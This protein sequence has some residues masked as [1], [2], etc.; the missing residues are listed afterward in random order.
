VANRAEFDREFGLFV[1]A[2][3]ERKLPCSLI[4]CDLDRFKSIN[5]TYGHPA[6]DSV[7]KSFGQLLKSHCRPG[8]LVARYGG[9]EFVVLC[10]DCTNAVAYERAEAMR[11]TFCDLTQENMGGVR[12]SASFGVTEIQ[13]GDSPAT[14][15]HRADRALLTAKDNGRNRVVQLGSGVGLDPKM[16]RRSW[17][18]S[19]GSTPELLVEQDLTTA[20]PVKIAVE[21]L[22]GFVADHGA[23]IVAIESDRVQL[24]IDVLTPPASG[25]RGGD[26]PLPLLVD[27]RFSQEATP[28]EFYPD[29]V[30]RTRIHA[31]IRLHK[32]RNRRRGEAVERARQLMASVRSYLMAS[33]EKT[34]REDDRGIL[35]RAVGAM[36]PWLQRDSD[37]K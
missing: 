12:A 33:V 23:V 31:A 28:L 15:L 21:K 8:D 37:E 14:M 25:R 32:A 34:S 3:L 11:K 9:E 24:R 4:I 20:V 22:R 30:A 29:G 26:R 36:A 1:E 27:L 7:I 35:L 16:E 5:D 2:H 6:G 17:W 13:P 10:A 18:W 19:R